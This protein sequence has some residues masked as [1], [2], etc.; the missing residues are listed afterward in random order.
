VK[1]RSQIALAL[2]LFAATCAAA[3][4]TDELVILNWAEYL[5]PV[6]V[7]DF[8]RAQRVRVRVVEFEDDDDRDR[9]LLSTNGDGYDLAI[10]NDSL[11]KS[12]RAR[13][14]LAPVT[15]KEVPNL[16]HIETRWADQFPAAHGYAVPYF[17]GTIGIAYRRDL[18][19]HAPT[20]WMDLLQPAPE[21][22]GRIA[23]F[24]SQRE[25]IG[26]ALKALGHSLNSVDGA[27]IDSAT[28]LLVEQRPYVRAYEMAILDENSDLVRGDISMR[29]MYSGDALMVKE[30]NDNIEYI[31]PSE[32]TALWVDFLVV[33][34]G[35][36]RPAL[37]Y[38]F[39]NH[40]NDPA[41]AAAN[42]AFV[43]YATPNSAAARLMPEAYASD[44]VIH[45]SPE[46]LH[47][48]EAFADLPPRALKQRNLAFARILH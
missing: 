9:L 24:T 22:R 44:P 27:A 47:K 15:P 18:L 17:W 39:I 33:L 12:Y 4:P 23:M 45:P 48:S 40:I 35:T 38:A 28:K 21:L 43:N 11:V 20:S 6:V 32:G 16:Q 41:N 31:V 8:E 42:A 37:A 46:I 19:P 3:P 26:V 25:T 30:Y 13:G 10:V 29:M 36:R 2:A 5:D 7:A 1:F 34:S 14:L